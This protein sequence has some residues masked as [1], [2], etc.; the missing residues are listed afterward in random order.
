M[1]IMSAFREVRDGIAMTAIKIINYK[2]QSNAQT[3]YLEVRSSYYEA[4]CSLRNDA[5]S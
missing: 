4:A 3:W 5:D 2:Y 1:E